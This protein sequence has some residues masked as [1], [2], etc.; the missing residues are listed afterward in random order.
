MRATL[1]NLRN[2]DGLQCD[3]EV[4]VADSL[5]LEPEVDLSH[6]LLLP[7]PV[8]THAHL[9]KAFLNDYHQLEMQNDLQQAISVMSKL[10]I[11]PEEIAH[12]ATRALAALDQNGC[13]AARSHV[14][15][16]HRSG[17][18]GLEALSKL[19][20]QAMPLQLVAL[21][22]SPITGPQG[23]GQRDLLD[24]A[25]ESCDLIGG[26]PWLDPNPAKA[27][28]I[29]ASVALESGKGLD[30]HLDETTNP[31]SLTIKHLIDLRER[32]FP[33]QLTASHAVSLAFIESN[34]LDNFAK[35]LAASRITVVAL[36]MTNLFLQARGIHKAPP[37]AITPVRYLLDRGVHVVA[38]ADNVRDPFYPLG[39]FDPLETA[40]YLVTASQL[41]PVEAYELVSTRAYSLFGHPS[42]DKDY[43]IVHADSLVDALSRRPEERILIRNGTLATPIAHLADKAMRHANARG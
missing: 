21:I 35:A 29:L 30:L 8:E 28:E 37:R 7:A 36:P 16:N 25:A 20:S 1:K 40:A 5:G 43:L 6:W 32:G 4:E 9:D 2:P 14:D 31:Y 22:G 10:R 11:T 24:R 34:E 42:A 23:K 26:A 13:A 39:S 27:I 17:L 38:G 15:V 19:R 18:A 12:R 41:T 33:H 3:L